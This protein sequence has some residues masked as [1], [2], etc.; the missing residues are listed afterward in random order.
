MD[1]QYMDNVHGQWLI[2]LWYTNKLRIFYFHNIIKQ[3]KGI[4]SM[5]VKYINVACC[6][7]FAVLDTAPIWHDP[8]RASCLY[9]AG[10]SYKTLRVASCNVFNKE[11]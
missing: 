2:P 5:L 1:C 10:C 6:V 8:E 7:N 4:L 3:S 9:I 11:T